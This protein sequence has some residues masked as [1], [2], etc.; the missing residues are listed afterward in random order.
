LQTVLVLIPSA[1]MEID[2]VVLVARTRDDAEDQLS[3]AGLAIARGRTIPG[4][5][6]SNLVVPLGKTGFHMNA[7]RPGVPAHNGV[8]R[9]PDERLRKATSTAAG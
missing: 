1:L 8:A 5:G 3:K 6:V 7:D 2:H 9:S 4:L